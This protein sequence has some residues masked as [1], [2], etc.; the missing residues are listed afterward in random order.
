MTVEMEYSLPQARIASDW[1]V[2][3]ARQI[4]TNRGFPIEEIERELSGTTLIVRVETTLPSQA[5]ENMLSD[6]EDYL[7]TGSEHIETREV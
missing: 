5:V 6:I 7:E 1:Q 4:E 2:S 3:M